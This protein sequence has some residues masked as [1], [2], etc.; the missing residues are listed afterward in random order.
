M[1]TCNLSAGFRELRPTETEIASKHIE[2][3]PGSR[4][5]THTN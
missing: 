5:N 2:A 3:S 4:Y 1:T